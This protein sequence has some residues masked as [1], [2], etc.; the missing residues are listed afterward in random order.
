MANSG[1]E[2]EDWGSAD[3]EE[4]EEGDDD[5]LEVQASGSRDSAKPILRLPERNEERVVLRAGGMASLLR[6]VRSPIC[7]VPCACELF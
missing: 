1:G 3:E 4:R 2:E 5:G 6:N 7:T